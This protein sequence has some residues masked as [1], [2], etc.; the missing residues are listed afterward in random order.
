MT[1]DMSAL[2]LRFTQWPTLES[3]ERTQRAR[4]FFGVAWSTVAVAALRTSV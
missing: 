4:S 1:W 3:E 2:L